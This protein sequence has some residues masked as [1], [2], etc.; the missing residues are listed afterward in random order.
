VKL[1]PSAAVDFEHDRHREVA[2][3]QEISVQRVDLPPFHRARGCDE[4]LPEHLASEHLRR[5]DV[6]ALAAEQV[7]LD[8]LEVEKLQHFRQAGGVGHVVNP[9]PR[10]RAAR[11]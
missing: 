5:A 10:H 6:A 2:A 1:L 11:A 4:C 9:A 3:A 7:V 8:P